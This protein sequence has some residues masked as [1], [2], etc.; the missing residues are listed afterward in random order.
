[1]IEGRQAALVQAVRQRVF[2][3]V[4]EGAVT[5]IVGQRDGL[6]QILVQF[7]RAAHIARNL[8]H[9]HGMGQARAQAV[10]FIA[11]KDLCLAE[12]L[13]EGPAVDDAVPIPLVRRAFTAIGHGF[14]MGAAA[15]LVRLDGE[16]R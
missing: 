9:L 4:T 11:D 10:V 5:Q 14:G 1:M 7:Q 3:A 8:R 13:A 12:Q 16:G 2:P 6:P 15:G